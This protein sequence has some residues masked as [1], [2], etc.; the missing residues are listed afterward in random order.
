MI[1]AFWYSILNYAPE[2]IDMIKKVEVSL[3]EREKQ[4]KIYTNEKNDLLKL[5]FATFYLNRTNRSGII[6]GGPIGG[7]QQKSKYLIDCRFNKENLINRIEKIYEN[8]KKIKIYNQDAMIFLKRRFKSDSFLF[9]DPPYYNKGAEL[10]ENSF[11]PKEHKKI[12]RR[13]RKL[14]VPWVL[15]YDCVDEIIDMYSFCKGKEYELSY[16]VQNKKIGN[17]I[18]FYK[19]NLIVDF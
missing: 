3:D 19:D 18:M 6:K 1:Y 7:Q 12:S 15:T 9:I 14:S 16:T 13:I 10:Y 17:E 2:F 11:T 5:G 8:R 4:K